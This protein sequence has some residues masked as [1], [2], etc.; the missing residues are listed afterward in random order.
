MDAQLVRRL[1]EISAIS[2]EHNVNESSLELKT[3]IFEENP[4]IHHLFDKR[5]QTVAQ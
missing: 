5:R 2:I 1:R 3:G 4:P